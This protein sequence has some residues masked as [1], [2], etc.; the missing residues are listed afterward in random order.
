MTLDA[1]FIF[2]TADNGMFIVFDDA[3]NLSLTA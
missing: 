2:L 3:L 1:I